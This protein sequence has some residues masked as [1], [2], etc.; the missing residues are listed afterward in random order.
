[1]VEAKRQCE[2]AALGRLGGA[3]LAVG[4]AVTDVRQD[5]NRIASVSGRSD[6]AIQVQPNMVFIDDPHLGQTRM[7]LA[8]SSAFT[9]QQIGEVGSLASRTVQGTIL[10]ADVPPHL[11]AIEAKAKRTPLLMAMVGGAMVSG[12]ITVIFASPWWAVVV[13]AVLG[14]LIGALLSRVSP[15]W[16]T[17][18]MV[19]F[20]LALAVTLLIW[21][22]ATVIGVHDLPTFALCGPL[23]ILVPGMLVTNAVLEIS[24]GDPISGGGRLVSGLLVWAMLAAGILVGVHLV[25]GRISA[26]SLILNTGTFESQHSLGLWASIPPVWARWIAVFFIAAGFAL[27]YLSTVRMFLAMTLTLYFSYAVLNL[28]EPAVGS[29]IAGG[30]SAALTLFI[31]RI[32]IGVGASWPSIVLFRPAFYMLVPGSLGL[33]TVLSVASQTAPPNASLSVLA[34]VISLTIGIQ[35]GAMTAQITQPLIARIKNRQKK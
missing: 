15:A 1:M 13:S 25:G 7:T 29:V 18:G 27:S 16:Q 26:N 32:A 31:S 10:L 2:N 14:L 33:V 5:L 28:V 17:N 34:A 6:L 3:L 35:V 11:D 22:A 12:A 23:V 30:I 19:A 20:A 24:G 21:T 8:P 9:L 4:Y